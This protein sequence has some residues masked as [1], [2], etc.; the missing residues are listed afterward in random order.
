MQ[1]PLPRQMAANTATIC[2]LCDLFP[3]FSTQRPLAHAARCA[4][5][6]QVLSG[7]CQLSRD[8]TC[9]RLKQHFPNCV[10]PRDCV[11]SRDQ[12]MLQVLRNTHN[13]HHR[14]QR[15]LGETTEPSDDTEFEQILLSAQPLARKL[16][17]LQI[18]KFR[19]SLQPLL[20]GDLRQGSAHDDLL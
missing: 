20:L 2:D 17:H 3:K 9:D 19:Q 4:N 12:L 5:A 16:D 15:L 7:V 6:T 1:L 13:A 10:H 11:E 14:E 18:A 8:C